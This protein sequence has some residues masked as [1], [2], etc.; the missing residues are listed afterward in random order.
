[1]TQCTGTQDWRGGVR[2]LAHTRATPRAH[3]LLHGR[4]AGRPGPLPGPR[5]PV[6]REKNPHAAG[7]GQEP[8]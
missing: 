7:E 2:P 4:R 8:D 5:P 3:A 6:P 1:M